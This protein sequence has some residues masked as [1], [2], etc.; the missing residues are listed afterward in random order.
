[1]ENIIQTYPIRIT[2]EEAALLKC[3]F[4]CSAA[5]TASGNGA[6]LRQAARLLRFGAAMEDGNG[7]GAARN[8]AAFRLTG[9]HEAKLLRWEE[10]LQ[11]AGD[12]L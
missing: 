5:D 4:S 9:H 11:T 2:G 10:V 8:R 1:M 3:G 12:G 6:V 7:N